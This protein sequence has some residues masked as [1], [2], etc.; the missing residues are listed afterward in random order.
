MSAEQVA[1]LQLRLRGREFDWCVLGGWGVDAL[2]GRVT[3]EHKDLDV[4]VDL[5]ALP[6][7]L[8]LLAEE[9]FR[10]ARA[11]PESRDLP[12]RH[13][14]LGDPPPSAFVL[15]CTDGREVDVHVCD[16][17]DTGV[18]LLWDTDVVLTT[19]GLSGTGTVG[20]VRVRCMTAD[21][22]L[23]CHQGYD[24]PPAHAAD[25][26]LLRQLL[27]DRSEPSERSERSERSELSDREPSR[28]ER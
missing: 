3:R 2:A 24:L 6:G 4:V 20:G 21:L 11:W 12:G 18:V 13:P 14:L 26:R 27:A 9:G 7:V 17:L 16:G 28:Q 8:D 1:G 25:V 19:A 5:A 15:A 22:Q 23:A 10:L